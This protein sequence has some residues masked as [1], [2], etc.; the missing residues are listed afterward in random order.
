MMGS[1]MKGK[2]I[3]SSLSPVLR[4]GTD[5]DFPCT[6]AKIGVIISLSSKGY[7][8]SYHQPKVTSLIEGEQIPLDGSNLS[9]ELQSSLET[10][11]QM[12]KQLAAH[13]LSQADR[14]DTLLANPIS[15]LIHNEEGLKVPHEDLA[16]LPSNF[17]AN[18]D[19]DNPNDKIF[20]PSK[21]KLPSP[22][23]KSNVSL[24]VDLD[25]LLDE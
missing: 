23:S 10:I 2:V 21:S 25:L 7:T 9:L 18:N 14:L 17:Y 12:C 24:D 13:L 20:V 4:L 16:S 3:H 19:P 11:S 8:L 22:K 15:N 6:P 5:S 1:G